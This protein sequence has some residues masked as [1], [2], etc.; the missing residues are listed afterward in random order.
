MIEGLKRPTSGS[1]RVEGLD[2]RTQSDAVKRI[3]G[4]QL[5]AASFFENLS[6]SELIHVFAACYD[7]TEGPR[8]IL[9]EVQLVEKADAKARELSGGQKQRLSLPLGLGKGLQ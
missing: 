9:E 3:I 4:V 5:Q 7:R 2:I 8:Q 1:I 6:L